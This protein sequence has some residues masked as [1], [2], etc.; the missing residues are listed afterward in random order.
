[1]SSPLQVILPPELTLEARTFN[2][3]VFPAPE[4]PNIAVTCPPGQKPDNLFKII[5]CF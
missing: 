2:R 4:D 1:M 5:L 3:V